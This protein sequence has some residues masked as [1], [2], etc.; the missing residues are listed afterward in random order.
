MSSTPPPFVMCTY[1][2]VGSGI[3]QTD[4]S[5]VA[6]LDAGDIAADNESS[7][8]SGKNGCLG[9]TAGWR[10]ARPEF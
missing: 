3:G 6:I 7:S 8:S 2:G 10:W 5:M 4:L 1:S 9:T